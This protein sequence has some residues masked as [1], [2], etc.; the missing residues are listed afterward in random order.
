MKCTRHK[1]KQ[2]IIGIVESGQKAA[3]DGR[4]YHQED[5]SSSS[6]KNSAKQLMKQ[7]KSCF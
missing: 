6:K 2:E 1:T 4:Q 5:P 7:W 3:D